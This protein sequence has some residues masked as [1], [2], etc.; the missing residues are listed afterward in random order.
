[1]IDLKLYHRRPRRFYPANF[2]L[3]IAKNMAS[4]GSEG[5]SA[6]QKR[7]VRAPLAGKLWFGL[8][9]AGIVAVVAL[10]IV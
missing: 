6:S 9:I 4:H 1:M 5:L 3:T 10:Q 2:E 8:F 7:L